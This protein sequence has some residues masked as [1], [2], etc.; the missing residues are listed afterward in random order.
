MNVSIVERPE[1]RAAVLKVE[2][3]GSQVRQAWRQLEGLMEGKSARLNEDYGHVF[4]PEWQWPTGVK[5]LWVGV[6]VPSYDDMPEELERLIIP[7]RTFATLTIKGD[8][9][10][11][12]AA[13][14]FLNEWFQTEKYER[15]MSDGAFGF[16]ANRLKPI[17][18]FHIAA[19]VIDFFD[20]DIYAP[21]KL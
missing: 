20:F 16:E 5:T 17:N 4:I 2:C 13:Y 3:D 18:P 6:E 8:R 15:D 1:L 9:K 14:R 12:D 11:M 7:A 21:I 10:Q 19:D